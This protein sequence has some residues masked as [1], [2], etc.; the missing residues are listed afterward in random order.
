MPDLLTELTMLDPASPPPAV[1]RESLDQLR[2]GVLASPR[3][4]SRRWV[5]VLA[6]AAAMVV[7][8]AVF[9]QSATARGPVPAVPAATPTPTVTAAVPAN[10]WARTAP[11]PLSP[12]HSSV[13]AWVDDTFLVVGGTSSPPCPANA[14]C[15]MPERLRD[16][17]RYDPAIDSWTKIAEAPS[18]VIGPEYGGYVAVLD[19]TIYILGRQSLLSYQLDT[20]QWQQLPFP[21]GDVVIGFGVSGSSLISVATITNDPEAVSIARFDHGRWTPFTANEGLRGSPGSAVI[22]GD[23]VAIT[24]ID[25]SPASIWVVDTID[26]ITGEVGHPDPPAL[27]TQHLGAI[28]L[29]TSH[30]EYVVW[31]GWQ[32]KAW[33]FNPRDNAWSSVEL[34]KAAGS[35]VGSSGGAEIYWPVTVSG[36]V[37]VRGHLYDPETRLWARTP[38]LPTGPDSPLVVSGSDSVLGCFGYDT[39]TST[40]AKDCYLLHPAAASL[41]TP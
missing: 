38:A 3:L 2:A 1:N 32:K 40:F 21:P 29:T 7:A 31:R 13:T 16:G 36:M 5:G 25:S 20:D 39:N 12:R 34:P 41:R 33:F 37:S 15:K 23:Q 35:F 4:S 24:S 8:V 17:A 28:V 18:D 30:A 14:D 10:T 22:V 27:E 19:R 9:W 26:L 11:S 6:A